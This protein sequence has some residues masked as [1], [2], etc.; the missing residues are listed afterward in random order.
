MASLRNQH[1]LTLKQ[2]FPTRSTVPTRNPETSQTRIPGTTVFIAA[3]MIPRAVGYVER[4]QGRSR[5]YLIP[6]TL[7]FDGL[8]WF[9][10]KQHVLS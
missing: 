7:M 2:P 3:K 6:I 5:K 4:Q 8:H 1:E 10:G 9:R